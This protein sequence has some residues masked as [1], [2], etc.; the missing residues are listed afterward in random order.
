MKLLASDFDGTLFFRNDVD[1]IYK[2][3]SKGRGIKIIQKYYLLDNQDMGCIGDSYNDLPML[4]VVEN[5]FTFIDS[6]EDIKQKVKYHI[7]SVSEAISILWQSNRI[8]DM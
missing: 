4:E 8:E 1:C 2:G 3:N 5:S 6:P 7:T